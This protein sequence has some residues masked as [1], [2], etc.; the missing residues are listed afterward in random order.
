MTVSEIR[1]VLKILVAISTKITTFESEALFKILVAHTGQKYVNVAHKNIET[2]V[3]L[4][5]L[6]K[7]SGSLTRGDVKTFYRICIEHG[8]YPI[9]AGCHTEIRDIHDFSWDHDKPKCFGGPDAVSNMQPMHRCCNNYKGNKLYSITTD[10]YLVHM[11]HTKSAI[12]AAKKKQPH[13]EKIRKDL[14]PKRRHIHVNGWW[15][16]NDFMNKY[17]H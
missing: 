7:L 1:D 16:I 2:P 8:R 15:D 6:I 5:M 9:C 12:A 10:A 4:D 17:A 13:E 3:L 14:Y 11:N